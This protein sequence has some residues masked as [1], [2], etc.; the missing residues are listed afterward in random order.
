M[1]FGWAWR[2]EEVEIF[3]HSK[4]GE[5]FAIF[6]DKPGDSEFTQFVQHLKLSIG[7]SATTEAQP[8]GTDNDGAAPRRV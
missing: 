3:H 8:A 7:N 1:A 5:A 2:K 4:G 6:N